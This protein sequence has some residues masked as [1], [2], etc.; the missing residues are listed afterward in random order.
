M[1]EDFRGH[2][3]GTNVLLDFARVE[4]V[5][6]MGLSLLLKLF[7]EREQQ[8]ARVQVRNLNRMTNMLFRITGLGRFV[9]GYGGD[10]SDAA[11]IEP[12]SL[13]RPLA[14][15][16]V[17][18]LSPDATLKF[19][20][21]LQTGQQLSGWY[22]LNT[23]LQRR[24]ERP[25][26]LEQP[27]LGKDL[28][29]SSVDLLFSKPFDACSLI[30]N[31]GFVPLMRPVGDAD[32]A[33]ILMRADDPRKLGDLNRP[34]VVTVSKNNF[35]YILGRSLC[36]ESGL[37]SG[38]FSYQFAG[39]EIKALQT[40]V[41]GKADVL[42]MLKK[43]YEGLS[44]FA[45]GSTRV[46]DESS[47]NFAFHFFCAAPYLK[48]LHEPLV[49]VFTEMGNSEQGRQVLSDIQVD[50]WCRPDEGEIQMLQRLYNLYM[51]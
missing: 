36:D 2:V 1:I 20:A 3:D 31:Q 50:G 30:R 15:P 43:T 6:S 12:A 38:N 5:N 47:T 48:E 7:E 8:G 49:Q 46:I 9:E 22:L 25:I 33:V 51:N 39:N 23:Y 10:C 32:E 24:L 34:E 16:S 29:E 26:H 35:V 18:K 27:Q 40:L 44:S 19:M 21:N 42:F 37:D 45:R 4:R 11:R 17:A 13:S 28:R 41:K 14:D